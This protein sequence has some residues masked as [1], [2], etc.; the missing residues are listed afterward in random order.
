MQRHCQLLLLLLTCSPAGSQLPPG[1]PW[2]MFGG[3]PRHARASLF[4]GPRAAP[5][6]LP[7]AF[8]VTYGGPSEPA[9][10]ADGSIVMCSGD[11]SVRR[12]D[13]GGRELWRYSSSPSGCL[14]AP[15]LA[16]GLAV[17]V[18]VDRLVG[19]F[20]PT[21][22]VLA[23]D[24]ASGAVVWQ[25]DPPGGLFATCWSSPT[26]T[27]A[28]VLVL[29]CC[30]GDEQ[31]NIFGLNSDTG[32]QLWSRLGSTSCPKSSPS[33]SS[34]GQATIFF[35]AGGVL[36]LAA[37]TGAELFTAS[38][39]NHSF[40]LSSP[41]L[42]EDGEMYIGYTL[43]GGGGGGGLLALDSALRQRWDLPLPSPV[44]SSPA[45]SPATDLVYVS[46][47]CA[48]AFPACTQA[49]FYAID[50]TG[51][52]QW[53]A[54]AGGGFASA[55]LDGELAYVGSDNGTVCALDQATGSVAWSIALAGSAGLAGTQSPIVAAPGRLLV[56]T[57]S[58]PVAAVVQV[59]SAWWG[60]NCANVSLAAAN[61]TATAAAA[62][63]GRPDSCFLTV[64]G[65]QPDP[66]LNCLKDLR[67][68]FTCGATDRSAYLPAHESGNWYL[69]VTCREPSGLQLLGEPAGSASPSPAPSA[70]PPAS[71]SASAAAT[72]ASAAAAAAA[73]EA[74]LALGLS[75]A[76]LAGVLGG[77]SVWLWGA[78]ARRAGSGS[79]S[80]GS[81]AAP[82][83]HSDGEATVFRGGVN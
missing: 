82:L 53:S 48:P 22:L 37:D 51:T 83:L 66:A 34:A 79:S 6:V 15:L 25:F 45:L 81:A 7:A 40:I 59:T 2:P 32:A 72:T 41:T 14:G 21:P 62:C 28:G 29:A 75:A 8:P 68:D 9:V 1:A 12:L 5:A 46:A 50:G 36:A 63:S 57:S 30:H 77:V 20:G 18:A 76:S 58:Y 60:L 54:R 4:P 52:L 69:F 27:P 55:V 3:S 80:G 17:V 49:S 16:R 70:T 43:A 23:L 64:A 24:F 74:R 44:R 10:A 67:V 47:D 71:A 39:P 13:A 61:V 26:I 78:W 56:V 65:L 19:A 42:T 38:F 11:G 33:L 31:S 73:A 35:E